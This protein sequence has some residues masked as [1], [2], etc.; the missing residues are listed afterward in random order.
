MTNYPTNNNQ[1]PP[2]KY[3]TDLIHAFEENANAENAVQMEKYMRN[4]FEFYG[5]KS[6]GRKEIYKVFKK[7]AGLIPAGSQEEIV[8]WCW[9]ADQREYQM[10]AME[11]L[12]RTTKKENEDIIHL[13]EFLIT[14]KSWW[15]TVDFIA[16]N[17][18]GVYFSRYPSRIPQIT[19]RWMEFGNIWL[20]RTCLLFQLK[21]KSNLNMELL[22]SFIQP[23]LPSKEF[24]IQKAIGWILREY[25]KT[26]PE[27]VISY[28]E[29][30]S[31]SNLSNR[32]ALL[33]INKKRIIT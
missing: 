12:G 3:L 23:L 30:N 25:S 6:P 10:F 21:Y 13:Y 16:S 22:D 4:K 28:V 19:N 2:P 32:E 20:Q 24:F 8:R 14:T 31:L 11:F 5:I 17:L 1:T 9:N 7:N 15:D 33:W 18:V 26:N 27:L 29:N